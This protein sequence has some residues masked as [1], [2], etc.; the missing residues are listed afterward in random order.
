MKTGWKSSEFWRS[1][2]AEIFGALTVLGVTTPDIQSQ[3]VES[4][5]MITGGLI[6]ALPAIGYI[7]GRSKVKAAEQSKEGVKS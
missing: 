4:A 7:F 3:M 2:A 1:L 5:G 6:M